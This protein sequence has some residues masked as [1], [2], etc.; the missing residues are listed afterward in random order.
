VASSGGIDEVLSLGPLPDIEVYDSSL[1]AG[2]P[3]GSLSRFDCFKRRFDQQVQSGS[4]PAF[5][6]FTLANDHTAGTKPGR[7]SPNAMVAENDYAL[8]QMVDL[9]SHS[10]IWNRSLILVIEDDAQDGADHVDAHR[11]P[12]LAISCYAKRGAVV[13][14]RY[15]FLSFIRTLQIVVGMK[16]LGLF[17]ATAVPLYDAFNPDPSNCEPYDAISP[18]VNL[19]ERNTAA[20]PNARMSERL[21]NGRT[22][23]IPQRWLDYI[24]W[25]SV[26]G[27][28]SV[29]PPPGP[30]ASGVDEQGWR[31]SGKP[32]P[33]PLR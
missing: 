11:I 33:K 14:T 26:H 5:N 12:A 9:I 15:D 32:V 17:D 16:P 19:T 30:N 21:L 29:P 8:G 18:N 31:R 2:A 20:S 10:P 27:R 22:D 4:V 6:Y 25:Q 28:D 23:G 1:P 7:R 3:P 13:H 24:L